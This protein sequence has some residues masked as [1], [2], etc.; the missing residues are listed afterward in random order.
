M[1]VV[2][3]ASTS[4]LLL[5]I[6]LSLLVSARPTTR[7]A[8]VHSH[9]LRDLGDPEDLR[10]KGRF[11]LEGQECTLDLSVGELRNAEGKCHLVF[12]LPCM[13]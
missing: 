2:T 13:V 12:G 10:G 7:L 11:Q 1:Y 4:L 3:I 9:I 6:P 5:S 8:T